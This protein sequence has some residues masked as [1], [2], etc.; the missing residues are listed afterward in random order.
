MTRPKLLIL[1]EPTEGIQPSIIR[2]IDRGAVVL[3][4]QRN[5]VVSEA[6]QWFSPLSGEHLFLRRDNAARIAFRQ[7]PD[8]AV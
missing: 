5:R 8:E 1:D 6:A 3:A 7:Q 2:D 4:G